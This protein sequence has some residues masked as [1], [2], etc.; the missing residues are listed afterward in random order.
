MQGVLEEVT[1]LQEITEAARS[2]VRAFV[3]D[4]TDA[5]GLVS[6]DSFAS[7]AR[8]T[9]LQ[10][11]PWEKALKV[12]LHLTTLGAIYIGLMTTL[13]GRTIWQL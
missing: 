6:T 13:T 10:A 12:R 3:E 7:F 4:R 8:M 1:L 2:C 5:A 11:Q 9:G